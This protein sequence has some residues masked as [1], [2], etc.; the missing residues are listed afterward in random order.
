MFDRR[1]YVKLLSLASQL[2]D[3]D[4]DKGR[5]FTMNKLMAAAVASL[6]IALAAPLVAQESGTSGIQLGNGEKNWIVIEDLR[7]AEKSKTYTEIRTTNDR[8]HIRRGDGLTL[9]FSEVH[10]DGDGW[11]VM[12]PF[13]DG[14]PSGTHVAGYAFV[15]DGTNKDVKITLNPAPNAGENYIVMLH[16]DANKDRVF[17][18]VFVA[19]NVVE[20]KA[21]FEGSTMIAHM[22]AIP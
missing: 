1:V 14:K 15:A 18:F 17:D 8:Q 3:S 10:I 13:M 21:V 12:H 22:V 2:C 20:D 7:R 4:P 6:S 16:S 9:T 5:K 11:L 19:E